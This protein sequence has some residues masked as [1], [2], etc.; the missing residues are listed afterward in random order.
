M[1]L[2]RVLAIG[3][4]IT[5]GV[6]ACYDSRIERM[7]GEKDIEGDAKSNGGFSNE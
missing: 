7:N 6:A 4:P 5:D 1:Q 2:Y 3:I